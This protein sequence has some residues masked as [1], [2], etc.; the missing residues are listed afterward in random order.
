V[1]DR[2]STLIDVCFEVSAAL[3][4]HGMS[5]V[6]VGGSAAAVYAPQTYTSY[7]ADFILDA[8]HS[9]HDVAVALHSIGFSRDG[10]SRIFVHPEA[11]F[12]VDFSK[13]PLAVGCSE[14]DFELLRR[15][16]ED[17]GAQL[18]PKLDEFK[19]RL[20]FATNTA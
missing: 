20:E 7:D 19:K 14:I 13:G 2:T 12:T 9:L 17:E 6:L 8:G 3:D 10:R 4:A 16:T 15:W 11:T 18:L 5:G 1:I